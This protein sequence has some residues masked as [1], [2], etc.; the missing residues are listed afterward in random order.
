MVS[1]IYIC[2]H[3]ATA[4]SKSGQHTG[5]S[6]IPLTE[7]GHAQA[8]AL[9]GP[10]SQVQFSAI[11]SSPSQRAART[12]HLAGFPHATLMD[13]LLEWDY[14]EYD[15]KTTLDIRKQIP[16]W[17]V[18]SSPILGGESLEEIGERAKRFLKVAHAHEG[19]ILFFS[20]AHIS[21][22]IAVLWLGW[23]ASY[24]KHLVLSPGSLSILGFE[25]ETPC[26]I[27]WNQQIS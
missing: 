25:R 4:W 24:A 2:R 20:S 17:S 12:A 16:N 19:K 18:F 9:K 14:G 23:P 26:L 6:D 10:L 1:E 11:Y 13:D 27:R 8:L 7:E 3:G 15:G 22:I 21:R 5:R